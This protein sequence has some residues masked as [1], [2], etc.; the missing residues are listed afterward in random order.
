MYLE[1][2]DSSN[3]E[4][5]MYI[6]LAGICDSYS[7]VLWDV[8]YYESGQFEVYVAATAETMALFR[9]DRIVGRSDDNSHYGIIEGVYL[10]TD[11]E[12]GDYLT[13]S[14]RFLMC[15]LSRRIIVP[16]LLI[17]TMTTYG[18]IVQQA[19]RQNC[20]TGTERRIPNLEIG[21]ITGNAWL[22][23]T[24]LQVSYENLMDWIYTICQKVGGTANIRLR[25][26]KTG[27]GLYRMVFELSQ[28]TDRSIRQSG[29]APVVFSDTYD[30]LL[31]YIYNNDYSEHR[32]YAYIY[33]EGEG[34]QRKSAVC[35]D[36]EE[37]PTGFDRYEIYV[38][39]SDLSQTVR[40]DAGTD[41]ALTSEE[42]REML[43][44][45]G[46]ESLVA[47]VLS[48][49]ATIAAQDHQFTYGVDYQV[50]D[51]ITMQHTGYGISMPR[52]RL[53]GMVESF[54]SDGYGLS[55]VVQE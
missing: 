26:T 39:A 53:I 23:K 19:V 4:S 33:G 48:S 52:V 31:T 13:I 24:K 3:T 42:Y 32:N 14:G 1:I 12:N 8:E 18:E 29:N 54:D 37:I 2:Y 41:T 51:W 16:T 27:S 30:N 10:R 21:G 44:E 36:T 34:A 15:L 50:G 40:N 43:R 22:N 17:S 45:R 38:N 55:P 11:A 28:G 20:T 6:Q 35:Y 9:R 47:P 25:E 46:E 7:S 49:E 5:G